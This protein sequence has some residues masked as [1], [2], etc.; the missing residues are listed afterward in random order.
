MNTFPDLAHTAPLPFNR[1]LTIFVKVPSIESLR[2]RLK[3]RG[4]ETEDSLSRRLFKVQF[5]MGFQDRFDVV[6]LNDNLEDTLKE[7]EKI[8][9][10]FLG[11][12]Q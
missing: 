4:T 9:S 7:A 10:D 3:G 1:S 2:D 11:L 6:L 8:V 5:E 12:S